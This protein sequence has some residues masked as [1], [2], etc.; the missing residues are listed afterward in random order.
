FNTRGQAAG[1]LAP[2]RLRIAGESELRGR[3]V[4]DDNVAHAGGGGSATN[5]ARF[6]NGRAQAARGAFVSAGGP[7]NSGPRDHDIPLLLHAR[8]PALKGSPRST[9]NLASAVT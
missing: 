3:V 4:H 7:Y 6:H 5:L 2:E 9:I 8:I 1:E